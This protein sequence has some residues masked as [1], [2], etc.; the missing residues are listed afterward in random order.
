M[1]MILI[2]LYISIIPGTKESCVSHQGSC[3]LVETRARVIKF[4]IAAFEADA[5]LVR[6]S[7][8]LLSHA[9]DHSHRT[10]GRQHS[11]LMSWPEHFYKQKKNRKQNS[12]GIG[13]QTNSL[14]ARA[15]QLS[16]YGSMV[17][18]Y[19]QMLASLKKKNFNF[20]N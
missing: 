1:Q 3:Y 9:M 8:S 14:S 13:Q 5:A 16:I 17:C 6:R 18:Q 12:E 7:S 15:M 10:L 19:R 4:D 11:G 2:N 20:M